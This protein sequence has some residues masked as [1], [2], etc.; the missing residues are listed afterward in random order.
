[1]T[2]T[3]KIITSTFLIGYIIF[4]IIIFLLYEISPH[5]RPS[6]IMTVAQLGKRLQAKYPQYKNENPQQLG[7]IIIK[8]YPQYQKL[9]DT[10][11]VFYISFY[12]SFKIWIVGTISFILTFS[13]L[14]KIWGKNK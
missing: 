9:V 5:I 11:N 14:Y 1:M 7:E 2:T 13:F 10:P 12:E 8:E 4:C 6:S 3:Q